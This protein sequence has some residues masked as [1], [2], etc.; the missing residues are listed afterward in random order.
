MIHR[1]KKKF[2]TL[3]L[4]VKMFLYIPILIFIKLNILTFKV[5]GIN[6]EPNFSSKINN[7]FFKKELK[8]SKL[9][10]EFGSGCSTLYAA[11]IKKEFISIE[12]DINFFN[13]MR[14]KLNNPGLRYFD[15]GTT[16]IYSIP[17]FFNKKKIFNYSESIF[18]ELE[19][20][21]KYPDLILID[22]RY[23]VLISLQ[24]HIFMSKIKKKIKIIIDDY[25]QRYHYH[26]LE[27]FFK[28]RIIGNFGIICGLLTKKVK[29]SHIE[30]YLS[31]YR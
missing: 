28:I 31:D 2:K 1:I 5:K 21:K 12:T 25:P 18:K 10:L 29:K 9:Y 27:K 30:K 4:K 20:K 16:Y 13:F 7:N 3:Y 22:G 26:V 15:I 11:K 24:A 6:N 23:R 14:L 8:K 19:T 17:Y